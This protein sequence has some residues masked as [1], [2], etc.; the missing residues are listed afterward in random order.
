MLLPRIFGVKHNRA[1]IVGP[2][3]LRSAVRANTAWPLRCEPLG[4]FA[5]A[6]PEHQARVLRGGGRGRGQERNAIATV[7][8]RGRTNPGF[9]EINRFRFA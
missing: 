9:A 6:M 5:L 4:F 8:V 1:I 3:Q 7:C 2:L